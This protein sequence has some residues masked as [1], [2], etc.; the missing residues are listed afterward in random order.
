MKEKVVSFKKSILMICVFGLSLASCSL[1]DD[2][3]PSQANAPSAIALSANATAT[4]FLPQTY[5][6]LPSATITLTATVTPTVTV[7]PEPTQC[8]YQQGHLEDLTAG[9]GS[10]PNSLPVHIYFPPCF[11]ASANIEYPVLILLPGQTYTEYQWDELGMDE[12]AFR[13][14]SEEGVRRFMIVMPREP[15][16]LQEP[17]E[18]LFD[19]VLMEIMLPWLKENFP[20]S[21]SRHDWA[22]GG[23]S[24]GGAWAIHIGFNNWQQFSQIGGHSPVPFI[25]DVY[26]VPYWVE[27]IPAE[28]LPAVY[29]D[30]GNGDGYF[31][32]ANNFHQALLNYD[33]PHEWLV[34]EGMHNDTYWLSQ[35]KKYLQWYTLAW[36]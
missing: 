32:Y 2:L 5:T 1:F 26:K 30:I 35:S 10:Y 14:I 33:V 4:A 29:L 9:E 27:E 12:E 23:I 25:S 6:P 3:N 31:S 34:N 11:E 22:I 16:Y 15:Y 7:T 36:R 8:A 18:S 20:V 24:R 21:V 19:D 17:A 13:L 28:Q